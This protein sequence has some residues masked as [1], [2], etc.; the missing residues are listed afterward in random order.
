MKFKA[1]C[2]RWSSRAG[3]HNSNQAA[4]ARPEERDGS[5]TVH[6]ECTLTQSP[7]SVTRRVTKALRSTLRVIASTGKYPHKMDQIPIDPARRPASP[8]RSRF[9]PARS[10]WCDK[11]PSLRKNSA[12]FLTC[13]R[14]GLQS[15]GQVMSQSLHLGIFLHLTPLQFPRLRRFTRRLTRLRRSQRPRTEFPDR[16]VDSDPVCDGSELCAT[17]VCDRSPLDE[18]IAR[19]GESSGATGGISR[20]GAVSPHVGSSKRCGGADAEGRTLW[21]RTAD[22]I[23]GKI[24]RR[25]PQLGDWQMQNR[26]APWQGL[27]QGPPPGL[28][29]LGR[30]LVSCGRTPRPVA[31]Y[32]GTTSLPRLKASKRAC[33]IPLPPLH[34]FALPLETARRQSQFLRPRHLPDPSRFQ[35]VCRLLPSATA[36]GHAERAS[37]P[38]VFANPMLIPSNSSNR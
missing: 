12:A 18:R 20:S 5:V 16:H 14:V 33:R 24:L 29:T 7:P 23:E 31:Q 22:L 1:D 26:L 10:R 15:P 35:K 32:T 17:R 25:Q 36:S 19:F 34:N 2:S 9:P 37:R 30:P 8:E 27:C 13:S 28:A 3:T 21:L 11:A 6:P 4:F 38:R